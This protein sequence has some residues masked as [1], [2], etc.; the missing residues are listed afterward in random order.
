MKREN[1]DEY[2]ENYSVQGKCMD[3]ATE[4]CEKIFRRYMKEGS[5]L[6]L[7]PAQGVMTR[8]LYPEYRDYTV[9]DGSE[10]WIRELRNQY[11][12]MECYCSFFEDFLPK[13][14]YDNI[15]L[16]HVLEH[17][18]EPVEILKLCK[19]W[20]NPDAMVLCAVPNSHSLHRQ[21]AVKMGML[22]AEEQLND[23]DRMV[24]HKRVYNLQMLCEH[25][26]KAGYNIIKAGGYWLKP[27]TITQ[28]NQS[29][30]YDMMNAFL[31]LGELYPDIAGEIYV[32]AA[33]ETE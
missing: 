10:L 4:Y 27:M 26:D 18:D 30:N 29:W 1:L 16:G 5:V 11:P 19:K 6:E 24:G 8:L 32:I 9:V 25:F 15:L 7:G 13:R 21:A 3:M 23:K 22:E 28:I 2:V 12:E 14:M 31:Q 20:L 33:S 17:V